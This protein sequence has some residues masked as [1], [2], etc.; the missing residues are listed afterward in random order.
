MDEWWVEKI[1]VLKRQRKLNDVAASHLLHISPAT[2]THYRMARRH[3]SLHVRIRLLDELGYAITNQVL[4]LIVPEKVRSALL[5]SNPRWAE[6]QSKERVDDPNL[7]LELPP[8]W[9]W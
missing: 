3:I 4:L 1:E 5:A 8:K 7:G 6:E 2:L 9:I